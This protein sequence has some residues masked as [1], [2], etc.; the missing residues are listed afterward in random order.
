MPELAAHLLCISK[1][2][3]GDEACHVGRKFALQTKHPREV[4]SV[5]HEEGQSQ[6][7]HDYIS[8]FMTWL[9]LE[10][11]ECNAEG[12]YIED[13]DQASADRVE[14]LPVLAILRLVHEL[15]A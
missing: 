5:K 11:I 13:I 8:V 7:E 4:V 2:G 1:D 6:N 12:K 14:K 9:G 10:A 3:V 15:N